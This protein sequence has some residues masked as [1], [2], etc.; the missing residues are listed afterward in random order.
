MGWTCCC[1]RRSAIGKAVYLWSQISSRL[2]CDLWITIPSLGCGG[3]GA[4]SAGGCPYPPPPSSPKKSKIGAP[5]SPPPPSPPPPSPGPAGGGAPGPA[6]GGAPPGGGA[7]GA[8][9]GDAPGAPGGGPPPGGGAPRMVPHVHQ[10]FLII[11]GF[12]IHHSL[13]FFGNFFISFI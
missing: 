11:H 2:C 12:Y 8:P 10:M 9:P 5:P 7:L 13:V 3:V 6:G 1:W 4:R